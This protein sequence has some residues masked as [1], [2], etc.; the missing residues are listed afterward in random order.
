MQ[1]RDSSNFC[2]RSNIATNI[3]HFCKFGTESLYEQLIRLS[4]TVQT[5]T[6]NN[7]YCLNT[8]VVNTPLMFVEI[9]TLYSYTVHKRFSSTS[10][11]AQ[12]ACIFSFV[13]KT[14]NNPDLKI[15]LFS[16]CMFP[17]IKYCRLLLSSLRPACSFYRRMVQ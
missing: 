11:V 14:F 4:C 7:N 1:L 15:Q 3:T 12:C 6:M 2:L 8:N 9:P 17:P 13:H 5:S 10:K 16:G